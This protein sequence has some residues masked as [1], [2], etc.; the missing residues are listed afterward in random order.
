M[1]QMDQKRIEHCFEEISQFR[2][3]SEVAARDLDRAKERLAE[4]TSEQRTKGQQIW[5]IIM[6]SRITKLAAAVAVI[7]A[8]LV[9]SHYLGGSID[10][11]T[12]AWARVIETI[13]NARTIT[14][15]ETRTLTCEAKELPFLGTSE[16]IKYA[17]SEYGVRED[18]VK[19]GQPLSHTYWLLKANE[20]V[21]IIPALK[22]CTRKP[23][24][25]VEK[26]VLHQMTPEG[27]ANLIKSSQYVELGRKSIDG[28]EVE[29]LEIRGNELVVAPVELDS[30]V[31]R[32]WV[33][34]ETYLPV[35][36]EADAITT[37]KTITTFTGGKPVKAE[38]LAGEFEWNVQLDAEIFEPNIPEDYTILE[39]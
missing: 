21:T 39:E 38:L 28:V 31:M 5:I 6:K 14:S 27:V 30:V 24:T 37:D 8:A 17:S 35:V 18:M 11:T 2:P 15:R 33:D 12:I 22:Q 29:G 36:I 26:K 3:R 4:L 7:I 25:E 1:P 19:D 13:E 16:V 9:T 34:V 10:G 20:C 23:L 32:M